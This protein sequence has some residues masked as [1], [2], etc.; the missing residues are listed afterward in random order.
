VR[1]T[2]LRIQALR[3]DRL[4]SLMVGRERDFRYYL[5]SRVTWRASGEQ[6]TYALDMTELSL[7]KRDHISLPPQDLRS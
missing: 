5:R 2:K 6:K 1:R 3:K 4:S 7:G